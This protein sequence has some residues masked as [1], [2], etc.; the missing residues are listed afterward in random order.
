MNSE[1]GSSMKTWLVIG[2]VLV[3]TGLVIAIG[4]PVVSIIAAFSGIARG[5]AP[6]PANMTQ[7]FG[8]PLAWSMVGIAVAGAGLFATVVAVVKRLL[9]SRADKK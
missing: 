6:T 8:G 1:K 2:I 7:G 3:V 9:A 4:A 5:S